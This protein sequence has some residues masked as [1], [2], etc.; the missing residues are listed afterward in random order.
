MRAIQPFEPDSRDL[1][2]FVP[3]ASVAENGIARNPSVVYTSYSSLINSMAK[4]LVSFDRQ[5]LRLGGRWLFTSRRKMRFEWLALLA[6][7]RQI[8]QADEAWTTLADISHLPAWT[9]KPEDHIATNIGRYLQAFERAGL[10]IVATEARWAG[11]F[12]MQ[13]AGPSIEFDIPIAE[14][15]RRLRLRLPKPSVARAELLRFTLSYVRAQWLVSQGRLVATRQ[16]NRTQDNAYSLLLRMAGDRHFSAKLRLIACLGAVDVLYDL[17]RFQAALKT[18]LQSAGL[19]QSARDNVLAARYNLALAW[20]HSRGSSGPASDQATLKS[21]RTATARAEDGGDRATLGLLAY[22][23]SMYLTKKGHHL[24]AINQMLQALQ[25]YLLTENYEGVEACCANIGSFVH[26][27]GE[28]YYAE[29]RR[30]LLSGIAISRWMRIGLDGAHGEMIMGKLYI[31][32]GHQPALAFRWLK[33]AERIAERAGNQV[34]LA[35][36]KMIWAFWHQ[37]FGSRV[38][39]IDNL[40]QALRMFRK[41]RKFDCKQKE[42]YMAHKFPDVWQDVV[43]AVNAER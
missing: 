24:E 18:L 15:Q 40:I 12:R 13:M 38:D 25:A 14:V 41:L 7:N 42:L 20:S 5:N 19:V 11:P 34:S 17:G 37:Q 4:L 22:R 35:D 10:D 1:R 27:L 6:F 3:S 21:L 8:K 9:G 23:T 29:A 28:D 36:V 30:W 39:E 26:R 31:E 32:G 16:R 43:R 2:I 33:R